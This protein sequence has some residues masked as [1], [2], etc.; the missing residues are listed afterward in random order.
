[1]PSY[2]VFGEIGESEVSTLNEKT[3]VTHIMRAILYG[4][5]YGS[6]E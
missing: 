3:K 2:P 6:Y 5:Q 4:D 1:M